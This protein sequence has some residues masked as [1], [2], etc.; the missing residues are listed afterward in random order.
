MSSGEAVYWARFANK[1]DVDG[2]LELHRR[3]FAE[4]SYRAFTFNDRKARDTIEATMDHPDYLYLVV[5]TP[6]GEL[7]GYATVAL[8][9]PFMDET[10]AIVTYLYTASEHRNK[11]CS[12][13][14][15]DF[16][17]ELCEHKGAKSVYASSTAGFSDNGVNE[18]AFRMFLKRNQFNHIG[19]FLIREF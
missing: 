15:L 5:V 18:R 1:A 8:D 2:L 14:L 12:Q 10:I 4:S 16:V 17:L 19:S 3:Y 11:H 9:S 6:D 7:A 13:S